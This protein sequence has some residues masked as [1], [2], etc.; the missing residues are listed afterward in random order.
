[1]PRRRQRGRTGRSSRLSYIE[2][3]TFSVAIGST[4]TVSR[5]TLTSLPIRCNWR[6]VWF[7]VE[8]MAFVPGT[9]SLPGF[10][11]PVACQLNFLEGGSPTVAVVVSVS[12]CIPVGA[13]PRRV[14]VVYPRSAD[15]RSFSAL[16]TE[17]VA[18][19]S[20]TCIG[21]TGAGTGY[22]RG[23]GR[24]LF[25]LSQE[26]VVPT[27]PTQHLEAGEDVISC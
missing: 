17:Q 7:E 13:V 22:L 16:D 27:C 10:V 21:T 4:T 3:F 1:M 9:T 5:S 20:A 12:R 8:A 6:P 25:N 26:D 23:V 24:I 18:N 11:A 15:W 14:R 2:T 19:I